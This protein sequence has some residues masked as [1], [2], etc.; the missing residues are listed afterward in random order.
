MMI[1]FFDVA[2]DA[3]VDR[4][5]FSCGKDSLGRE[6]TQI[7]ANPKRVGFAFTRVNSR[8]IELLQR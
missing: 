3:G 7:D 6:L 8:R 2:V 5:G 1:G 4:T